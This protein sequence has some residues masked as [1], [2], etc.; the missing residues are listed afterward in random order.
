MFPR[1]FTALALLI[2]AQSLLFKVYYPFDLVFPFLCQP[3]LHVYSTTSDVF[4]AS[5]ILK[6]P[7]WAVYLGFP[8]LFCWLD[9]QAV[10]QSDKYALPTSQAQSY[11][12]LKGLYSPLQVLPENRAELIQSV[13]FSSIRLD[14]F[15][16]FQRSISAM[17]SRKSVY[18]QQFGDPTQ[19]PLFMSLVFTLKQ[20]IC[21]LFLFLA[22]Q[23]KHLLTS[24]L[25]NPVVLPS[26]LDSIILLY[27]H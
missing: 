24:T 16:P 11:E 18:L 3:I 25:A 13:N 14:S 23:D 21:L 5:P 6:Y 22:Y 10:S 17:E 9:W 2:L 15:P 19:S 26:W 27:Q 8:L 1:S 4:P 20:P 12:Q 7:L